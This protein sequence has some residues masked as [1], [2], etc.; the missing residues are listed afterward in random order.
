MSQVLF[1]MF[2]LSGMTLLAKSLASFSKSSP[3]DEK[4]FRY[5]LESESKRSERSSY[6]CQIL[7]V[8]RID[9]QGRIAKMDSPVAKFVMAA[10]SQCLRE[11]DYIGW[12]RQA[13]VAGGVLTIV[14]RDAG[15]ELFSRLQRNLAASLRVQL[16]AEEVSRLEIRMCRHDELATNQLGEESFAVN[17]VSVKSGRFSVHVNG[18]SERR[19]V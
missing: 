15:T 14:R 13:L 12:Y 6:F 17:Q 19:C 3:Y 2:S 4:S 5:L 7:L 1:N 9:P 18:S 11:T 10:L 8:Y 16:G